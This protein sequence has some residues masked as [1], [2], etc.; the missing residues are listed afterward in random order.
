MKSGDRKIYDFKSVGVEENQFSQDERSQFTS[1][2][3]IGIKSPLRLG[4]GA[5]GLFEMHNN[6]LDQVKD[7]LKVLL[8]TNHGERVPYYNFGANLL[9]LA[10]DLTTDTADVEAM[11]RISAALSR[12]MPMVIPTSFEPL[13]RQGVEGNLAKSGI[14][15]TYDIPTLGVVDQKIDVVI[16]SDG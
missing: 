7:N 4:Q 11:R 15:L 12:W 8:R 6:L 13:T 10:F 2:L 3:P 5:D 14:R 9:P 16:Y 1:P